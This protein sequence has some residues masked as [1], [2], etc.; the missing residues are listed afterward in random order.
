LAH[1]LTDSYNP[2]PAHHHNHAKHRIYRPQCLIGHDTTNRRPQPTYP[3]TL[4]YPTT[5]DYPPFILLIPKPLTDLYQLGD[6]NTRTIQ[7]KALLTL[8]ELLDS[9]QVTSNQ[10]DK[11]AKLVVDAIDG[12]HLLAQKIWP[13]VQPPT[14][15]INTKIHPPISK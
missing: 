14:T 15:E 5:R 8:R 13:M 6:D 9:N 10:I 7:Q 12:Y 2:A 4:T 3:P 11:A 1:A